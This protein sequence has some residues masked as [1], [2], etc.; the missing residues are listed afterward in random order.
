MSPDARDLL[1]QA[2]ARFPLRCT[3]CHSEKLAYDVDDLDLNRVRRLSENRH[4]DAESLERGRRKPRWINCLQCGRKSRVAAVGAERQAK[5]IA[6]V[7]QHV[8]DVQAEH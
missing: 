5:I 3:H 4:V 6:Y 2:A 1:L 8:G 7:R